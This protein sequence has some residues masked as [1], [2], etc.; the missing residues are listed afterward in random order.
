MNHERADSFG[1]RSGHHPSPSITSSIS[2]ARPQSMSP[3]QGGGS[4]RSSSI[5]PL[6]A[7]QPLESPDLYN[8]NAPSPGGPRPPSPQGSTTRSIRA[9]APPLTF[10]SQ[11]L[12]SALALQEAQQKKV[13]M[14]GYLLKRDDQGADGRPLHAADEKRRW[15]EC[16][17]QLSGTVLSL[18]S[19]EQMDTA[20]QE[21]R[22]VPPAYINV[23]DS[24]VDFIGLLVEDP[25]Q[26][27]GSR[28]RY[29]HAFALNSAGNNRVIFCFRD[30]PPFEPDAIEHWLAPERRQ[31]P[32]HRS[33]IGWLNLGHRHLQAWINA[34]RLA[35]WEKVRLEEIYTGALIRARLGAVGGGP[36]APTSD[37]HKDAALNSSDMA[38]KSPLVK[39]KMEGWVKARF[40]GSTEW[41]KCWMVLTDHRPDEAETKKKFWKLGSAG[42]RSSMMSMNSITNS[43]SGAASASSAE[44]PPPPG[45][46]GAPGIANF[47]D[48]KKAKKPF[49]SLI[50][51]AHA[52]AVYPSR[53]ELVEGSSLF[54]I[55]GVFPMG[56]VLSATHRVRT[57]G[58]VMLMPELENPGS[59]GAN[60]EMMKWVIA[61]MDAFK[62]YGRPETFI[63]DAR[64][65]VSAFFA[66][67]IGP[68]KERLFLDRELAEFLEIVR[69]DHLTSRAALHGIMAARMRGERTKIL[70]PLPAP[71]RASETKQH[72]EG[73][74]RKEDPSKDRSS[75]AL[76]KEAPELPLLSGTLPPLDFGVRER[77]VALLADTKDEHQE[78]KSVS[79]PKAT[80]L[81]GRDGFRDNS[82]RQGP[83]DMKEDLMNGNRPLREER[84]GANPASRPFASQPSLA[85]SQP[86]TVPQASSPASGLINPASLPLPKSETNSVRPGSERDIPSPLSPESRPLPQ[87]TEN[88]FQ[89]KIVSPVSSSHTS[90]ALPSATEPAPTTGVSPSSPKAVSQADVSPLPRIVESQ[91]PRQVPVAGPSGRGAEQSIQLNSNAAYRTSEH[92]GSY[93][94]S[95]LY[96]MSSISDQLP[97]PSSSVHPPAPDPTSPASKPKIPNTSAEEA[98]STALEKVADGGAPRQPLV[99]GADHLSRSAITSPTL[100]NARNVQMPQ[101]GEDSI[102]DDALAAYSFLEQPPSPVVRNRKMSSSSRSERA[103]PDSSS[104]K[105][106]ALPASGNLVISPPSRG[107]KPPSASPSAASPFPSSFGQNRRA[108]ERK[109]AAQLQAQA[110]QEALSKPGRPSGKKRFAKKASHAWG[111]ESS[112]EEDEDEEEEDETDEAAARHDRGPS[113]ASSNV[114]GNQVEPN[115]KAS[116]RADYEEVRKS[117]LAAG[118]PPPPASIY[119][120]HAQFTDYGGGLSGA[121]SPRSRSISPAQTGVNKSASSH[122]AIP[123]S[124]RQSVFNSHLGAAHGDMSRDSTPPQTISGRPD[125]QTFLQLDPDEQPGAM[126]TVFTPHGL[127]QAGAQDKAERSAKAQEYEARQMGS[128]LVNVPNKPPPP[129][130]GL[131][132][133]ITAHERDRKAAGGYGATLTER[134]RERVAAE[135][136]QREEDMLR[137]QQQQQM[138]HMA[139]YNPM[140][141]QQQMMMGGMMGMPHMGMMGGMPPM[142]YAP[143]QMGG[144]M[145]FDPIMAQQH[146][147]QA[148]QMAYMNA[149]SQAHES[150]SVLGHS[151]PAAPAM[152]TM[153]MTPMGGMSSIP[154]FNPHMSMMNYPAFMTPQFGAGSD[155]GGSPRQRPSSA[156][157]GSQ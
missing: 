156:R 117:A 50:Y 152:S 38:I 92:Y 154:S 8:G 112:E 76:R 149:M 72:Q 124:Q 131:L 153:G 34:I 135:R 45:S 157:N 63:W 79:S 36:G 137:Q 144:Q 35:S 59:K 90:V 84:P 118:L 23:T 133:A 54:K 75:G 57:T 49:A 60:A 20:A 80:D 61:F 78:Q 110:H 99:D 21:G 18:W 139:Y 111:E 51:A 73:L 25:A 105:Q 140:M 22:E 102:G 37:G 42:D 74:T 17:V 115:G 62:L 108:V 97:A 147:M 4:Q 127:V 130:A 71:S 40:M 41:K 82:T 120:E 19:V 145:G 151:S 68:Y 125:R 107:E 53:P 121:S 65:P 150:G 104:F 27:P 98:A 126:T 94:E 15:T 88:A 103:V 47:Y 58:W 101:N 13:Y 10:K 12:R 55:E 28:G 113:L 129:Q 77:E 83:S 11:D 86:D 114:S 146:A 43:Q 64:N 85:R 6:S 2:N 95:A 132:G 31:T 5:R 9:P 81:G 70:Q 44:L 148:A 16:F 29:H 106:P 48:S 109:T 32:E 46:N 93:D 142:G 119:G 24:F 122:P 69:E 56:S 96:Y 136:R 52:F 3:T 138:Q 30:P 141:F 87:Q 7:F 14:E 26:V 155:F 143:S 123:A 128:H 33:V 89:T 1:V 134:E 66:Y 39:G 67:P 91:K 100:Q 116:G